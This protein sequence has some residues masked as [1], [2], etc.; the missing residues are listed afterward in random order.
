MGIINKLSA[1]EVKNKTLPGRYGDGDGLWLQVSKIG[2]NVSKSWVYRFMLNG[3]ARHMGL[4]QYPLFNLAEAR[5]RRDDARK[6]VKTGID[7]VE[8]R[9]RQRAEAKAAAA[10]QK[11]FRACAEE[12]IAN[13]KAGWKNAKHAAQ[14]A[15]TLEAYVYP[16][17]GSLSVADVE[18]EHVLQVV[19]P[20]W[21]TKNETANRVRSRIEMIL[22]YATPQYRTGGNPSRWRILKSK[23]AARKHVAKASHHPALPYEQIPEF[24]AALREMSSISARSLEFAILT[25]GRTEQTIASKWSEING[26]IWT[27]PGERMK[28][29]HEHK[30]PLCDRA[31]EILKDLPRFDDNEHIF[32]GAKEGEPLS[33][34]AMLQLIRGMNEKREK[35]GHD[36]WKDP[37]NGRDIVTH[38]FRSTFTDWAGDETEFD[39]ETREFST[40]HIVGDKTKRAYRR[41]NALEKRRK[42][43][44]LW[45]DYC[46]GKIAGNVIS[47]RRAEQ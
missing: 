40:H 16:K 30:V 27:I 20:I 28:N 13:K 12:Y 23:L 46:A 9:Q 39:E 36:R 47:M 24:M 35:A 2:D 6:L 45:S 18:I 7:P 15:S 41:K 34:M 43:M 19:R 14:W 31:V 38:G 11:T 42:L 21:E 37:S 8:E 44:A 5:A 22:D 1:T 4:G 17:I 3:R 26:R 32:P 25:A 10:K 29:G 33:N